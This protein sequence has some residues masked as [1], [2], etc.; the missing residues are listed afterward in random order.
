MHVPAVSPRELTGTAAL[1]RGIPPGARG[2]IQIRMVRWVNPAGNGGGDQD[3]SASARRIRTYRCST[4]A[5]TVFPT[6]TVPISRLRQVPTGLTAQQTAEILHVRLLDQVVSMPLVAVQ[7]VHPVEI[8]QL[9]F[10]DTDDMPVLALDR[11]S[12]P[13]VQKTVRCRSCRSSSSNACPSLYNDRC[14]LVDPDSPMMV[15]PVEIPQGAFLGRGLHARR[16]VWRRW[17]DSAENCG[18]STGAV[19]G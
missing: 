7:T 19:L 14:Q 16:C 3:H 2:G 5:P 10:L 4:A 17:P 11:G 15:L 12:G 6:A 1:K 13:D 9:Q 18:D 8:P